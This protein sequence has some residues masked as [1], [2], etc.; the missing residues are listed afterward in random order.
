MNER[1]RRRNSYRLAGHDYADPS[2]AYFVTLSAQI[3]TVKGGSV[4]PARPFTSCPSLAAQAVESL[5]YYRRQGKW[6]LFAYCLMPDHLHLL[7]TP[8]GGVNLSIVLGQ[9]ESF[10]T[11]S[12]WGYGIVG[13]LWQRSFHDHILRKQEAAAEVVAYILNNPVRGGLVEQWEDWPWCGMP[14][15]L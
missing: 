10:V 13:A 3:K 8:E 12:A 14:D 15:A 11:R 9:Y 5:T 1:K 2:Y 6:L 7:V 4:D